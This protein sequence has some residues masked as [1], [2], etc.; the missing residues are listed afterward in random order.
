MLQ[1]ENDILAINNEIS[2]NEKGIN[3]EKLHRK[4]LHKVANKHA[5]NTSIQ[6]QS[7]GNKASMQKIII[8]LINC[9]LLMQ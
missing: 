9:Y 3:S 4:H 7:F 5:T 6:R 8:V 1:Q 2:I